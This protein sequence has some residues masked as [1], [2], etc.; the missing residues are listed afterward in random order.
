MKNIEAFLFE[1]SIRKSKT[2]SETV[3]AQNFLSQP[4]RNP[5]ENENN[6]REPEPL[7]VS[8]SSK[9]GLNEPI[10]DSSKISLEVVFKNKPQRK[11]CLFFIL[12][13]DSG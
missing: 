2:Q 6:Q 11:H 1:N 4:G 13:S 5:T 12:V 10:Q 7:V 8:G 9:I 3:L